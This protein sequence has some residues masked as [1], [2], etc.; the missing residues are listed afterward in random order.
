MGRFTLAH[1]TLGNRKS[2]GK[3]A[4]FAASRLSHISLVMQIHHPFF[5][6][7]TG[8]SV[9]LK[10]LANGKQ[11]STIQLCLLCTCTL[12]GTD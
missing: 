11:L 4:Q 12:V 3:F 7:K 10:G 5:A 6:T 9:E 2:I 8:L 1:Y